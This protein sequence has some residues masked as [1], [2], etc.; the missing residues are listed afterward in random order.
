MRLLIKPLLF[1][2]AVHTEEFFFLKTGE[3]STEESSN[4]QAISTRVSGLFLKT[5]ESMFSAK[6]SAATG[7]GVKA[8][9]MS[10]GRSRGSG[11]SVARSTGF[12]EDCQKHHS[13]A[14]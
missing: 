13:P 12:R 10:T 5:G 4:R 1:W 7:A 2:I 14:P 3:C 8:L 6:R 11:S 9:G